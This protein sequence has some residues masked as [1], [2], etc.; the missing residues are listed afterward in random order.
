MQEEDIGKLDLSEGGEK[1]SAS[2]H[3]VGMRGVVTFERKEMQKTRGQR[4][5]TVHKRL[6]T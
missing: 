2:P 3:Y 6:A 1:S 5:W 4:V